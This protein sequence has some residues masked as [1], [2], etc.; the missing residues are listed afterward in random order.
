MSY[1]WVPKQQECVLSEGSCNAADCF[2][3]GFMGDACGPYRTADPVDRDL[4]AE[5]RA[6]SFAYDMVKR[7]TAPSR[8]LFMEIA[9][10]R[11]WSHAD[12]TA[13]AAERAWS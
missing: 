8:A 2:K 10:E 3:H 5:R 7:H 12:F 4:V 11:G 9:F 1:D 13:W 6:F